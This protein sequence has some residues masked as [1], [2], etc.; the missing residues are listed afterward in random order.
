MELVYTHWENYYRETFLPAYN[1]VSTLDIENIGKKKFADA[2]VSLYAKART[3]MKTYL[4]NNGDFVFDNLIVG[5]VAIQHTETSDGSHIYN[6]IT[7][8]YTY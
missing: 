2:Y 6:N 7:V 4:N 1:Y 3:L 8:F 5:L